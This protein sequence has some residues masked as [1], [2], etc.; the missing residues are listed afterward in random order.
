MFDV[1][2]TGTQ[3][4]NGIA[5]PLRW[6]KGLLDGVNA[7]DVELARLSTDGL[8]KVALNGTFPCSSFIF[9]QLIDAI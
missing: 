4:V 5:N 3:W 8:L 1:P 7:M 6:S 9:S 2:N